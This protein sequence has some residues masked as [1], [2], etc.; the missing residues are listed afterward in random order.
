[1]PDLPPLQDPQF[2]AGDPFA[3]FH[4]LRTEMPISWHPTPGFWALARHDDVV[5][6][7]RDA[8]TFCTSQGILLADLDR[9][10]I[11]R[12]SIVYIDPPEHTQYRKLVQPAFSPGRLRALEGRIAA[13]VDELLARVEPGCAIDFVESFAAPL[14]LLVIAHLLGVPGTDHARFKRWSDAVIDAGT[15]VTEETMA[16]AGELFEYF[17]GFLAARRTEPGD[18]L[19]SALV[20][21]EIDGER[22]GE[23]DLVMFCM[24]LLVAGNETTRNLLSHGAIALATHPEERDLL[25]RTPALMPGAVEEML[26][27]GSPVASFMRT[28]TRDAVLRGT[29]LREGDRVLLLYASANRDETVFGADAADFRVTRD[30]GAH[31]AFGYGTHFCLGAQLARMEARIA[32]A[33]LLAR[34]A[35][36]DL[37]GS[38]ERL[39]SVFMRGVMRLPLRL[40]S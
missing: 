22:L 36:W 37:A 19:I 34:F 30:A 5:A 24:S 32:F 3:A 31:V 10:I 26:R 1:M 14:P 25:A 8:A 40:S 12:Q 4:W 17:S 11:P 29:P 18:D 9:P 16:Q 6:V 28:A 33:A 13:L 38:V 39:P 21:S 15:R 20:H 35:R 27:W 7:S 23:F 2:H